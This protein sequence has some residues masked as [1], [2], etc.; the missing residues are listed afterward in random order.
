MTQQVDLHQGLFLGQRR[1]LD[2]LHADD[3]LIGGE[4]RHQALGIELA[5]RGDC[6]LARLAVE[7]AGLELAKLAKNLGCRNVDGGVHVLFGLLHA[8][9]VALGA[10]RNLADSGGGVGGVLLHMQH[11]FGIQRID[12]HDLHGIADFVFGILAQRIGYRHFASGDGNAHVNHLFF[13]ADKKDR[14]CFSCSEP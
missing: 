5:D 10:Q 9:D 12:V 2:L 13:A 1:K 7:H 6:G 4:L 3:F 8:Y 14:R 11:D